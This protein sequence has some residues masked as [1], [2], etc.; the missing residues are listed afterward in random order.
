MKVD[1]EKLE[2]GAESGGMIVGSA[3][4]RAIVQELRA[5]RASASIAGHADAMSVAIAGIGR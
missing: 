2:R 4:L 3:L 1:I 5:G